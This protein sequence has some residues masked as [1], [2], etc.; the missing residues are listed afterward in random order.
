[1]TKTT[2]GQAAIVLL[3][4]TPAITA[5]GF[6]DSY[7]ASG[8]ACSGSCANGNTLTCS[9]AGKHHCG[10]HGYEGKAGGI[11][12][13]CIMD[14]DV[15]DYVFVTMNDATNW[16]GRDAQCHDSAYHGSRDGRV[17]GGQQSGEGFKYARQS[18]L[19]VAVTHACGNV[20]TPP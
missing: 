8:A 15:G 4:S 13:E 6:C 5:Q 19:P 1:M 10:C 11:Q 3:M 2:V 16:W 12:D 9:W 7:E 17:Y 18:S 20:H 14:L